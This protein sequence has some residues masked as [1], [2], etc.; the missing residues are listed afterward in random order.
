[1][2]FKDNSKSGVSVLDIYIAVDDLRGDLI[3]ERQRLLDRIK[4][5]K[6]SDI[7]RELSKGNIVTIIE[8]AL[9]Y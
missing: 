9:N 8:D 1:L 2:V 6:D 4:K 7:K 5:E 3:K